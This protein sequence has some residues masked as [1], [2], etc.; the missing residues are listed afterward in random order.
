MK[1]NKNIQIAN[2]LISD[3]SPVFIIAEAGVNHNGN[4]SNAKDLIDVAAAAGAD[5][6]KFQAFKTENLILDTVKKAPYQQK[7]T[8]PKESQFDMLKRLEI[9]K[10][11][12]KELIEYCE[13]NNI[14]FLSTPFDEESIDE[15]NELDVSA[16]KVASTD[17]TNLLFLKKIAK[18]GKPIFLSTGMSYMAEI[19]TALEELYA[20][21][22]DIILLQCTAN[23]PIKDIEANLNVIKTFKS[24]FNILLGYSDHSK[25]IG[26]SPYAI[27]LGV[28]VVEKHFTIDDKQEGPDHEA[29]LNPKQLCQYVKE[30]RRVEVFM[31]TDVKKPSFDELKTRSSLQKCLVAS[32][33]ILQNQFFT[34][35][36]IIAK[37]TGG[38]GI[39]PMYYRDLLKR[40][41]SR[42][43]KKNDIINE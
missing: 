8:N 31:G 33:N 24:K 22:K 6:V 35:K 43:Y 9:N 36:N 16:F 25:G 32:K 40:K 10:S 18:T 26:A 15:L 11:Q 38:K 28:R 34:E 4:I 29:S 2:K 14:I 41:A 20:F 3:S 27:P 39:S 23:Y 30:I 7:T 19:E 42:D 13:K 21:N 17:T 1:F 37:R 12:N 5:A